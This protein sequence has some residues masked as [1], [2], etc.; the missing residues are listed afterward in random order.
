[1]PDKG[2]VLTKISLFWFEKLKDII[3][4]HF[5]TANIDEMPEEVRQYRRQLEGRVM[6]VKKAKVVPLEAIVRGYLT[7]G[8]HNMCGGCPRPNRII[9]VRDGPNTRNLGPYM[10]FPSRLAFWRHNSYQSP[11]SHRL[12]KPNKD[13][14]TRTFPQSEVGFFMRTF[15][16]VDLVSR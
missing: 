12:R 15:F 7:G 9:Q 14:M 10:V 8:A 3:P 1:M 2:K 11:C 4:T 5:V 16:H 6:L 13:N